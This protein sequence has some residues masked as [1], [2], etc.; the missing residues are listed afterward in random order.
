MLLLE[1]FVSSW[2]IVGAVFFSIFLISAILGIAKLLWD[3]WEEK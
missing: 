2:L 3:A 1:L